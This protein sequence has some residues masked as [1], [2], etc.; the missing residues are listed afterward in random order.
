MSARP[1]PVPNVVTM[2]Y[3]VLTAEPLDR[4]DLVPLPDRALLRLRGSTVPDLDRMEELPHQR[5]VSRTVG[6]GAARLAAEEALQEAVELAMRHDGVI[7]DLQTPRI[8]EVPAPHPRPAAA[9]FTFEYDLEDLGTIRT[10]G[11]NVVGLPE[12]VVRG[13]PEDER[14]MYDMVVVGLVHRLL[15]EWPEHDPVGPARV[16]LGDITAGYEGGESGPDQKGVDVL[17]DYDPA[18]P[19][20]T[21]EVMTSPGDALF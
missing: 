4:E 1:V 19:A 2:A 13:V 5:M 20:L 14:R 6:P 12:V 16:T 8:V 9:M 11:L 7:V 10:H 15:E 21:V 3:V 18:L 17:I